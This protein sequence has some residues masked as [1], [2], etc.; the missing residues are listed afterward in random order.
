M[1]DS[2]L[3]WID[4]KDDQPFFAVGWTTQTH[5]PYQ[6]APGQTEERF[7]DGKLPLEAPGLNQYLNCMAE[8]DRQ[9]GRLIDGLKARGLADDTLLVITGD[10]GEAF[11]W[12]HD[13]VG[14]GFALYQ[15]CLNVPCLFW[16]P[17][18]FPTGQRLHTVGGHIDLNPTVLDLL[19]VPAPDSWQGRSLL[20]SER[21]P[22][23]YFF[24]ANRDYLLGVRE[25]NFKYIYNVNIG[26]DELFDLSTDP[27][28]Q[29]DLASQQPD[30][31]LKLRNRVSAWLDYE[32]QRQTLPPQDAAAMR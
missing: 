29:L 1:V 8:D 3:N 30:R 28:E 31:C 22:R 11:G 7:C 18:A 21:P 5:H 16:N 24:A 4:R 32:Q 26:V 19:G 20:D 12:P 2:M 17:R 14:H 10:H 25:G 15:E 6:M 23:V 27:L 9:I 13:T